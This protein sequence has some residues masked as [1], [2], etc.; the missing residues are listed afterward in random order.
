M[1]DS[2]GDEASGSAAATESGGGGGGPAARGAGTAAESLIGRGIKG[3]GENEV[4][5]DRCSVIDV[6]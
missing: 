4:I 3:D 5:G 6:R 2:Y 1:K